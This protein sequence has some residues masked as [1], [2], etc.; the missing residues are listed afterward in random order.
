M[1]HEF[2]EDTCVHDVCGRFIVICRYCKYAEHIFSILP[3]HWIVFYMDHSHVNYAAY[4]GFY[5]SETCFNHYQL[6]DADSRFD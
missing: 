4:G 3:S 5:C 1:R 6:L 2:N